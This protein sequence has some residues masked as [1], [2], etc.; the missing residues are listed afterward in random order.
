[1]AAYGVAN[2]VAQGR[3]ARPYEFICTGGG[4]GIPAVCFQVKKGADPG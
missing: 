2:T 4:D 3:Q 1:M